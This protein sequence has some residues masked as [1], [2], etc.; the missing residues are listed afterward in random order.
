MDDAQETVLGTWNI[1]VNKTDKEP[2]LYGADILG[3]E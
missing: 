1:S 2:C 3:G